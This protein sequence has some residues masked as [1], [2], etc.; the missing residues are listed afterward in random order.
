MSLKRVSRR[1]FLKL[2]AISAVGAGLAAC[3]PAATEAPPAEEPAPEEE[4]VEPSPVPEEEETPKITIW[5]WPTAVMRSRDAEGNDLFAERILE[6]IG[7]EV[8]QTLVQHPD[9]PASLK[10]AIPAGT[11]PDV[12]ATDWDIL[13]PYWGFMM[14]L[15]AFGE[16]EWGSGW[17]TD[18]YIEAATDE[19]ELVADLVGMSGDALYLPGNMQLLGWFYYWIEDFEANGI[20][21][22]AL[23]TWDDFEQAVGVLKA[24]GLVPL[25]GSSHPAA[26]VDMFQSL[27][28]VTA[29]DKF[30]KAQQGD[31]KVTDPEIVA[32]FELFKDVFDNL[33]DEGT[34][35]QDQA[36][37]QTLFHTHGAVICTRF[38]G[39]PWFGN[40]NNEDEQIR[41]NMNWNY[42]TFMCPGSKGLAST[43]AGLAMSEASEQKDAAWEFLKW[44]SVGNGAKHMSEDAGEPTASRELIP[45]PL[46]TDFDKNLGEPLLTAMVTGTNKFRRILCTDVYQV[47]GDVLPGVVLG[48]VTAEQAAQEVQEVLDAQCGQWLE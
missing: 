23:V 29:P 34:L 33:M 9:Y 45:P 1:E 21:K 10:A 16:A 18:L 46:G 17:K 48:Q 47:L 32:A 35:G 12:V 36:E 41:D 30:V 37:G 19:M 26:L 22:D 27:V 14:P 42:G 8:E 20:D 38:T 2:A 44:D 24:A 15:N 6:D 39:T 11:G 40:L 28:E 4:E 31:G 7:V 3:A 5:G 25:A 43:D 13:G